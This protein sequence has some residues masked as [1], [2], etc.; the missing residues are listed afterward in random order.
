EKD[1]ALLRLL[2][3]TPYE[4][5]KSFGAARGAMRH[6]RNR[7]Q[8][9]ASLVPSG[10]WDILL[11]ALAATG[12]FELAGQAHGAPSRT[13]AWDEGPAYRFELALARQG[14]QGR[15]F[16]LRGKLVRDGS[17]VNLEEALL[18]LPEGLVVFSGRIARLELASDEE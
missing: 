15:G 3:A 17:S 6:L 4:E 1:R 7:I 8:Y 10:C 16:I 14:R 9:G 11:P 2:L 12:R 13:L 18:V 5:G